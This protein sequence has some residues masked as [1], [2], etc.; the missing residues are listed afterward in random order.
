M[1]EGI[2]RVEPYCSGSRHPAH[3][4]GT[5]EDTG[6]L[7]TA[8]WSVSSRIKTPSRG[9]RM[10]V[11]STQTRWLMWEGRQLL[12]A[13][14]EPPGSGVKSEHCGSRGEGQPPALWPASLEALSTAAKRGCL[15]I[16]TW[17]LRVSNGG[18]LD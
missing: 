18:G 7:Y 17:G 3:D 15:V 2:L 12:A 8:T 16:R 6:T 10:G 4:F 11:F 14:Q 1:G 5:L 13:V 9:H